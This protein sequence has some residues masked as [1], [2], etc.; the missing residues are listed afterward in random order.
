MSFLPQALSEYKDLRWRIEEE[1]IYDNIIMIEGTKPP[2]SEI[3]TKIAE[4]E[5]EWDAKEYA[6]SRVLAFPSIGDQLDMQ[7]HDLLDGTTTWKDA[8]A[9]VKSDNPKE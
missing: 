9:K 8:V 1:E 3:N 2:E 4:L 7:Y 6:R 5:A